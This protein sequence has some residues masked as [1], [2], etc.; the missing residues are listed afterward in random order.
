MQQADALLEKPQRGRPRDPFL[1]QRVFDAAA[2]VY[3]GHGWAGFNFDAVAREAGVG[4]AAIYA[5]WAK[6]ADLL[7]AMIVARWQSL[8]DIN[9]GSLC[10][11]LT[12]FAELTLERYSSTNGRIP[13]H[14]RLDTKNYA[15]VA[16]ALGPLLRDMNQKCVNIIKHAAERGEIAADTDQRLIPAILTAT[17]ERI[18]ADAKGA[19]SVER[20]R[21]QVAALVAIILNGCLNNPEQGNES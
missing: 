16:A 7:L 13:M 2:R 11:D 18:A 4:K 20:E 3:G 21:T 17:I 5:R 1:E 9:T 15:E 12:A 19:A 10:G 6:R 8:S 14:L